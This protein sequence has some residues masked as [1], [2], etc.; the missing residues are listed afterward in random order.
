MV[1]AAV[2]PVLIIYAVIKRDKTVAAFVQLD[3]LQGRV[4]AGDLRAKSSATGT[5]C[6]PE[7]IEEL[8][9][10]VVFTLGVGDV[11]ITPYVLGAYPTNFYL[12]YTF[13]AIA[14]I[15]LRSW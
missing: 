12:L 9:T 15:T 3:G 8:W 7:P 13:K 6:G 1:A 14:L 5:R 2:P 10:K 11:A 4:R